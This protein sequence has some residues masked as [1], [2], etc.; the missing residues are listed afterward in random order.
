MLESGF[1]RLR[2]R[3]V[4]PAREGRD[5]DHERDADRQAEN[6]EDRAALAPHELAPE[7]AEEEHR[8]RLKQPFLGAT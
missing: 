2:L 7:I 5:G 8:E 6:R 4:E 1:E 3:L